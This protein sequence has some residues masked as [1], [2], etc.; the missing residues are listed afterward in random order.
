MRGAII[1]QLKA[2][3]LSRIQ[4][5]AYS[6]MQL[7]APVYLPVPKVAYRNVAIV[8]QPRALP[9]ATVH[10]RVHSG[11]LPALHFPVRAVSRMPLGR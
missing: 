4:P 1:Y 2:P 11:V 8:L 3:A 5:S 10:E 6:S 9:C 7:P